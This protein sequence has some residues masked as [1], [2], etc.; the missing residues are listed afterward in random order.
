[1][2][3]FNLDLFNYDIYSTTGEFLNSSCVPII[4]RPTGVTSNTCTLIDNIFCKHYQ[5]L[6][7]PGQSVFISSTSDHYPIFHIDSIQSHETSAKSSK[8]RSENQSIV[9]ILTS[10][11]YLQY[12]GIQFTTMKTPHPTPPPTPTPTPTPHPHPH[13]HPPPTPTPHP[14]SKLTQNL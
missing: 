9:E 1:M 5:Q 6:V 14:P 12:I 8:R 4:N 2:G 7:N 10:E 3:D 13:P 11:T